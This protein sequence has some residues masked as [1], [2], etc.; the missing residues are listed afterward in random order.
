MCPT[1]VEQCL[2]LVLAPA[3]RRLGQDA[4]YSTQRWRHTAAMQP[5]AKS[6]WTLVL[7][8]YV[9][10]FAFDSHLLVN[11]NTEVAIRVG[12]RLMHL[13][14]VDW[15]M[16]LLLCSRL[17][18]LEKLDDANSECVTV[19]FVH[20]LATNFVCCFSVRLL[21]PFLRVSIYILIMRTARIV[22]GAGSM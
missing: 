5:V 13:A 9:I 4:A 10:F 22:C 21:K 14:I 20:C 11:S 15:L 3:G 18:S 6:L 2:R 8:D 12:L 7:F 19:Y 17:V 16:R 1:P